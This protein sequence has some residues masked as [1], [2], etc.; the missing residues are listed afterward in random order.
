MREQEVEEAEEARYALIH[1]YR[2]EPEHPVAQVAAVN[3][4]LEQIRRLES[5]SQ[6]V[7]L[8]CDQC[9]DMT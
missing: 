1:Q 8:I 6:Q 7:P 2:R 3:E 5:H 9:N 4:L